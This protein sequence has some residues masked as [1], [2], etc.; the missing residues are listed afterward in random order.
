MRTECEKQH[1]IKE[2]TKNLSHMTL[3]ILLKKEIRAALIMPK[4]TATTREKERFLAN[5]LVLLFVFSVLN[6]ILFN[7][8]NISCILFTTENG[9][10]NHDIGIL[11]D[12]HNNTIFK[13]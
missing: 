7:P 1:S 2:T 12:N 8:R 13:S 5:T 9:I 6:E 4:W 11:E 3:F 10:N